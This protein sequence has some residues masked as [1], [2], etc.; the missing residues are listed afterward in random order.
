MSSSEEALRALIDGSQTASLAVLDGGAPAVSL[1]P[2]VT[3]RSPLRFYVL[4]S[5]LSPH[6]AALRGDARCGWMIHEPPRAGD[7]RSNHALTRLMLR[8]TARF[9]ARSE[10]REAGV[11][12]SYRAKY[13]I[14]ET[15]LGLADFHF[16]ELSPVAGSA[17]FVQGFGRAYA[18]SG[19][20][21]DALEHVRGK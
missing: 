13:P 1:V 14:A 9:M 19:A 2:Y 21:L 17:S 7:P 8:A 4:V 15:L 12:A 18:A 10:A 20:D 6:T 5:E 16:V 3:A 11:E